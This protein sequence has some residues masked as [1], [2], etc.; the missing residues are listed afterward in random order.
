MAGAGQSARTG[1]YGGV[2]RFLATLRRFAR[3]RRGVVMVEFAVVFGFLVMVA[4]ML[5]EVG[6]FLFTTSVLETALL[7]ASR[8]NRVALNRPA[9]AAVGGVIDPEVTLCLSDYF[10]DF[11]DHDSAVDQGAKEAF[12]DEIADR[13]ENASNGSLTKDRLTIQYFIYESPV[14]FNGSEASLGADPR[15]EQG[16]FVQYLAQYRMAYLTGF[17]AI[18]ETIFGEAATTLLKPCAHLVVQNE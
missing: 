6:R 11:L 18:A 1:R 16:E 8:A 14:S 5:A 17:D 13:V 12:R 3:A 9:G 15:G 2:F 7:D 10:D 4:V